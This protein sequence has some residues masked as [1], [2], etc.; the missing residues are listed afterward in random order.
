MARHEQRTTLSMILHYLVEPLFYGIAG[1][2][3]LILLLVAFNVVHHV[4][5]L[6]GP[7]PTA[8]ITLT[9]TPSSS[10][11]PIVTP[12]P[13]PLPGSKPPAVVHKVSTY[14]VRTGDT[15]WA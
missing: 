1:A 3:L 6:P 8:T 2:G 5:P 13:G 12:T 9:P 7:T 10:P 4:S 14:T 15:L 11:G